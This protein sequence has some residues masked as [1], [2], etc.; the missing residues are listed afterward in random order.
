M[1]IK[2]INSLNIYLTDKGMHRNTLREDVHLA[3]NG[4]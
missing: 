1:I 3:H 4:D 2:E